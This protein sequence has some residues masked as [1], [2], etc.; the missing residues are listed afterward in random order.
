M[1]E[2]WEPTRLPMPVHRH[3]YDRDVGNPD[4]IVTVRVQGMFNPDGTSEMF[5]RLTH[6]V[7]EQGNLWPIVGLNPGRITHCPRCSREVYIPD[8][9]TGSM[10]ACPYRDC[11][12]WLGRRPTMGDRLV[13]DEPGRVIGGHCP[14]HDGACI[15]PKVQTQVAS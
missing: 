13:E 7:D 6:A 4:P 12:G 8:A 15:A 11:L 10:Y 3:D 9:A 5:G 1:A 14:D 2:S